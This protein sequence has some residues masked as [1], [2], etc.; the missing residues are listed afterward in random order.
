M[1]CQSCQSTSQVDLSAEIAIHFPGHENLNTPHVYV[2]PE[3]VVCLDCGSTS[4][5]VPDN[6]LKLIRERV[7]QSSRARAS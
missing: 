2:F 4:F 7:L 1:Q 3:I 6:E 5:K